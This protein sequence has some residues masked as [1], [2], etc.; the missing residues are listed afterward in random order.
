MFFGVDSIEPV[1][2]LSQNFDDVLIPADH[3][4]RSPNDTYYIDDQ[5]V[6]LIRETRQCAVSDMHHPLP[7]IRPNRE[8]SD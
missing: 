8:S 6:R 3:V 7:A 1:V 4:S 5:T 2:A